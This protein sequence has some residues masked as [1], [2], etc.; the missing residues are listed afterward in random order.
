MD[1]YA[2]CG[3]RHE[4][5]IDV[6]WSDRRIRG[7]WNA[8]VILSRDRDLFHE[9]L[10]CFQLLFDSPLVVANP[11]FQEQVALALA[12]ARLGLSTTSFPG[13][14]V[15]LSHI[16]QVPAGALF[17]IHYAGPEQKQMLAR[18]DRGTLL[19]AT[20]GLTAHA[21]GQA[22]VAVVETA[23]SDYRRALDGRTP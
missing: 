5:F 11:I 22:V 20:S 15:G 23:M 19:F 1:A 3:A 8:G 6:P 21:C 4:P 10:R 12:M 13:V 18:D 17:I 9:W 14:N 16:A 2:L 7:Y